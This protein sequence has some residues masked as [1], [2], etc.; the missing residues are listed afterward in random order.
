MVH[1]NVHGN[2][3]ILKARNGMNDNKAYL[4][5]FASGSESRIN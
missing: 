3:V 2:A 5:L 1:E 4:T